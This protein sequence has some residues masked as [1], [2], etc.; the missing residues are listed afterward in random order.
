MS[1]SEPAI[2][3]DVKEFLN[4]SPILILSEGELP[5]ETIKLINDKIVYEHFDVL[6]NAGI[7]NAVI[8]ISKTDIFPQRAFLHP[9]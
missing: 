9:F 7:R 1:H 5:S 3:T 6:Q 8:E 2:L 4:S